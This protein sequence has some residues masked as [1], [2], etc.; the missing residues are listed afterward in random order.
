M[1]GASQLNERFTGLRLCRLQMLLP[2]LPGELLHASAKKTILWK[3]LNV[4]KETMH[5]KASSSMLHVLDK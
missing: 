5:K 2:Q 3:T 1:G 4:C